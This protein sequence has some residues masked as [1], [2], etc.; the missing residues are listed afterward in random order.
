MAHRSVADGIIAVHALMQEREPLLRTMKEIRFLCA[1][2][3]ELRS[4]NGFAVAQQ[5][6]RP[7]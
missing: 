7:L 5:R 3:V 6:R 1:P 4:Q 2:D